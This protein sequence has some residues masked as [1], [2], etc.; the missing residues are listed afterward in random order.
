MATRCIDRHRI[1]YFAYAHQ[2]PTGGQKH[3]YRHVDILNKYG[4]EAYVVHPLEGYR[5]TWFD[6][7]TNVVGPSAFRKL[8]RESSD[9]IVLPEDLGSRIVQFRGRKVIF[10]KN[11]FHGFRTLGIGAAQ[12]RYPYLDS[13]VVAVLT[14]SDHNRRH[15][16]FAYPTVNC[17]RVFSEID[18]SRFQ[19][20][21]LT[22]KR[23]LIACLP[24]AQESLAV[25]FHSLRSRAAAGLNNASEFQWIFLGD[26]SERE[27]SQIL[28]E[29]LVFVFTSVA[30]GLPRMPLEAMACG[31]IPVGYDCGPITEVLPEACRFP[32][33]NLV[34]MTEF[35]ED[36]LRS[37][38]NN[39]DRWDVL[40]QKC[41]ARV[42]EYSTVRQEESVINAWTAITTAKPALAGQQLV[43]GTH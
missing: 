35:V 25:V 37:Y 41:R 20:Q 10:D 23:R 43:S 12:Q 31:C 29:S 5:L 4:Y 9:F 16:Q 32:H 40:I 34:A 17:L 3:T 2:R 42:A 6:N 36:I 1:F 28:Q 39:L 21:P 14:V 30:E 18:T 13:T 15:L 38:P 26:R 19:F 8:F 33:S 27:V 11:V 24:K 7:Q 22:Q